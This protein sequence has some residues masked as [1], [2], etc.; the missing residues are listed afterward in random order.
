MTSITEAP[1]QQELCQCQIRALQ[2]RQYAPD[3]PAEMKGKLAY[4]YLVEHPMVE[5]ALRKV[6]GDVKVDF[7]RKVG[8]FKTVCR[9]KVKPR[10]W[11]GGFKFEL[12]ADIPEYEYVEDSLRGFL[13][14]VASQDTKLMPPKEEL[15]KLEAYLETD[16]KPQWCEVL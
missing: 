8:A 16:A 12:R 3:P 6:L 13:I 15:A 5:I 9:A 2:V 4:G 10:L 11:P 7:Q 1:L 14:L